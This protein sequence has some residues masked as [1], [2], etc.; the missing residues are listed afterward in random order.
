MVLLSALGLAGCSGGARAEAARGSVEAFEQALSQGDGAAA[1]DLLA[2]ETASE[3]ANSA[4][5]SCASG[6]LEEDLPD[7][8]AVRGSTAWGRSAQVRL[9]ADTVF[10]SHFDDG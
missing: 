6:V 1:C 3:V 7:G 2:P 9:S 4:G 8:G 5:T 10:L